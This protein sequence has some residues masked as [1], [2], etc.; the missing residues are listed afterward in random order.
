MQATNASKDSNDDSDSSH[1]TYGNGLSNFKKQAPIPES[2]N[3]DNLDF[4][5][6]PAMSTDG[7]Q[8]PIY[9]K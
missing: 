7:M 6:I 2:Y 8:E 4:T 1:S 5:H 3:F 9:D